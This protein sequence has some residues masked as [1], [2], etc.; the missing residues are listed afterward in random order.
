MPAWHVYA[1]DTHSQ[2]C[3]GYTLKLSFVFPPPH[4]CISCIIVGA[5]RATLFLYCD[6]QAI[7]CP[8]CWPVC[9][10]PSCPLKWT[11]VD[12]RGLALSKE[13]T[14]LSLHAFA[15]VGASL[16]YFLLKA[17]D[18]CAECAHFLSCACVLRCLFLCVSFFQ[19][20]SLT[21]NADKLTSAGRVSYFAN[22][23]LSL[24]CFKK[25]FE[26]GALMAMEPRSQTMGR[27]DGWLEG[28]KTNLKERV[29]K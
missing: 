25:L 12:I 10:L 27:V 11:G 15:F 18:A 24:L 17:I 3:G 5:A 7:S 8:L 9:F 6:F 29:N 22:S 23:C 16:L 19:L 14:L 20:P 4:Q 2:C 13:M 1:L 26:T 28:L 21:E